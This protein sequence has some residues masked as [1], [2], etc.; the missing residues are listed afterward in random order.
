MLYLLSGHLLGMRV[1]SQR[2]CGT[3][4]YC[5]PVVGLGIGVALLGPLPPIGS[6]RQWLSCWA[7]MSSQRC[8]KRSKDARGSAKDGDGGD[9][10]DHGYDGVDK[11][12]ETDEVKTPRISKKPY[13]AAF[14]DG[15]VLHGDLNVCKYVQELKFTSSR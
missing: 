4:L 11:D 12:K 2:L 7:R 8:E 3:R 15:D 6:D 13:T 9:E 1:R 14:T 10:I 5:A